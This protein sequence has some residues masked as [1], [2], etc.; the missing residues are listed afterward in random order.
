MIGIIIAIY[1]TQSFL[2][3]SPIVCVNSGCEVVR[4]SSAS[5]IF[6]IPVP[7]FGLVGYAIIAIL[8]LLRTASTNQNL[9]KL[10][11]AVAGGGVLFVTWFTLTEIFVIRGICTWC[12]ISAL[13]MVTIFVLALINLKNETH[14]RN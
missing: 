7:A 1:V 13:N 2:R 9:G 8:A 14:R 10:L 11:V 12:A 5:Y 3:G 4:Q 6:G